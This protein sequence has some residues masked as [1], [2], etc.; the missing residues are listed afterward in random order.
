MTPGSGF[1]DK[2]VTFPVIVLVCVKES[3]KIPRASIPKIF[4]KFFMTCENWLNVSHMMQYFH[5]FHK[6]DENF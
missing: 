1:P 2:S 4:K 6:K 3:A 5:K